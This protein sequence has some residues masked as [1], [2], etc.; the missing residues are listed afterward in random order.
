MSEPPSRDAPTNA[1]D[2]GFGRKSPWLA[3][4]LRVFGALEHET[5][6]PAVDRYTELVE[7]RRQAFAPEVRPVRFVVQAPK[8]RRRA[9]GPVDRDALYDVRITMHDEV[10]SR[11]ENPHDFW[12]AVAWAL[13]PRSK[14]AIHARQYRALVAWLPED[15]RTIPGKRTREQD[16]LT[17]LD[18]GGVLVAAA[19]A[20][21]RAIAEGDFETAV[22]A[23]IAR[24][25]ARLVILGH[26]VLEHLQRGAPPVQALAHVVSLGPALPEDEDALF[27]A[28]DRALSRDVADE[29]LFREPSAHGSV[30]VSADGTASPG[31]GPSER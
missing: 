31:P 9:P 17:I 26:A 1:W 15:A 27:D 11:P 29:T 4:S 7:S 23:A 25:E 2:P 28:I 5:T 21:A 6:W 18:E 20:A 13:F 16:A 24:G 10:P 8:P 14:R 30:L 3:P 12:N 22:A 19:D